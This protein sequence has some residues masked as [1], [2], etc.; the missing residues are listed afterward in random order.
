MQVFRA[1]ILNF[2]VK[3]QVSPMIFNHIITG[4]KQKNFHHKI[5]SI[6]M[7]LKLNKSGVRYFLL[8]LYVHY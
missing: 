1:A 3:K 2:A 4:K 8:T 6:I 7:N 5:L